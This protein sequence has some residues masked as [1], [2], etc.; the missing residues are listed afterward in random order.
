MPQE[1]HLRMRKGKSG[2]K[3]EGDLEARDHAR[4]A[5]GSEALGH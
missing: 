2:G 3:S 4:E 5:F 1:Y